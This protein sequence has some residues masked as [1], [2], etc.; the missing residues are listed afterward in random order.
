MPSAFTHTTGKTHWQSLLTAR[1]LDSQ[2]LII[3][4]AQG[5]T[6]HFTH[7]DKPQTRQTWGH[8]MIVNANG[9]IVSGT[10]TTDGGDFIIIY[11]DFDKDEQDDI[12]KNMPIF[13]F[14]VEL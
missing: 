11:A 3:G 9:Q 8:G 2:C 5:G 12:R 4:S 14:R 1:A 10:D 6:H 13:E 7:K